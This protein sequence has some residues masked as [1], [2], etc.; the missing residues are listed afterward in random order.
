MLL[1]DTIHWRKLC[2]L[3]FFQYLDDDKRP[4]KIRR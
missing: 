4:E 3:L 2:H 1:I